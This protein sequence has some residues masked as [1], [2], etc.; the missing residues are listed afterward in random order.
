MDAKN[1]YFSYSSDDEILSVALKLNI[2]YI[3]NFCDSN[4]K[5]NNAVCDNNRFWKEKF[6]L[7]FGETE[8]DHVN[9]WKSSYKNYGSFYFLG[10]ILVTLD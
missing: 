7:D 6:L 5:F 4:E 3:A 1:C 10:E 2:N 9:D 8:Y